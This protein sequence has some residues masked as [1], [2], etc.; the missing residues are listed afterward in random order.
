MHLSALLSVLLLLPQIPYPFAFLTSSGGDSSL[1]LFLCLSIYR[2]IYLY[3]LWLSLHQSIS[4]SLR[5]SGAKCVLFQRPVQKVYSAESQEQ[6][7]HSA[8]SSLH[9]V[10]ADVFGV[11]S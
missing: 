6:N 4:P 9:E 5:G 2:S 11:C 7:V 8:E 3:L 1:S 10:S